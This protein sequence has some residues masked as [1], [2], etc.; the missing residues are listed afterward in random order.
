M[1]LAVGAT[2]Y[3]GADFGAFATLAQEIQDAFM[4]ATRRIARTIHDLGWRG[5]VGVDAIASRSGLR[6]LEL[7]PRFQASTW[8]L[9]ELERSQ[10]I[11][12][13]GE[14]QARNLHFARGSRTRLA[15]DA[16][17]PGAGAT[18]TL[19]ASVARAPL[20]VS[21]PNGV[22]S[23]RAPHREPRPG[24]GLSGLGIEEICVDGIAGPCV[25]RIER[26]AALGRLTTRATLTD[27]IALN[28]H[29]RTL[30]R[31]LQGLVEEGA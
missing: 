4:R 17:P 11:V 13:L 16:R 25:R 5:L 9:A 6:F 28:A 2:A 14:L 7:N 1:G 8:L 31:F 26:N 23:L 22:Y 21:A 24:L 27:G 18:V 29:G 10:G 30:R 12:P 19:R 20:S 15:I 3:C